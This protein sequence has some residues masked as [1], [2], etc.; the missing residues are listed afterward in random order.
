MVA[1]KPDISFV[2]PTWNNVAYLADTIQTIQA[3]REKNFELIVVDDCSTDTTQDLLAYMEEKDPRIH[4]IRNDDRKGAAYSR[5]F[6]NR[7]AKADIICVTDSG[8]L[9]HDFKATIVRKYFKRNPSVDIMYHGLILSGVVGDNQQA[10]EATEY[11]PGTKINFSHP[12][13][14]YRKEVALSHKYREGNLDTDQYEAFF[15]ELAKE[16]KKFGYVPEAYLIKRD[17]PDGRDMRNARIQKRKIYEEF[18]IPLPEFLQ[19]I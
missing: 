3:Q 11:V 2:L 13:V 6:G 9:Y 12:T 16:G 1:K 10:V 15:L 17:I 19:N 4:V 14:A 7:L 8:D 18:G 5:N